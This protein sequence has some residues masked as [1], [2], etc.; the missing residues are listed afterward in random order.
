LLDKP[1][2]NSINE[3]QQR[4]RPFMFSGVE[5]IWA[6]L[7]EHAAVQCSFSFGRAYDDVAEL[8]LGL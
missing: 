3:Q 1:A 4:L 8:L 2:C 6:G 7:H 5:F